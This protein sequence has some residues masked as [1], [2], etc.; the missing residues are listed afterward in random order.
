MT[1]RTPHPSVNQN[2]ALIGGRGCG[3]SS[4]AT[5]IAQTNRNFML[6]SL[7]VLIRYESGAVTIREIVEQHG[8][9]EFRER[10]F[11][12]LQRAAAFERGALL[13]CGGG[14]V[15][16]LDDHDR[17]QFSQRKV[18][19][20]RDHCFVVYLRRNA[21]DLQAR[22]GDDPNRPPLSGEESFLELMARRDPWYEAAAHCV[23][24]RGEL[25]KPDLVE[26]VLGAFRA[27]GGIE[28]EAASTGDPG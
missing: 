17:E 12:A 20:L 4:V 21:E 27:S 6:L 11:A 28:G 10:E 7:D 2:L 1:P 14:I 13:D 18:D 8:W 3:K 5:R 22:I 23:I 16:D 24:E 9:R 26:A 25:S 15:V 19:L